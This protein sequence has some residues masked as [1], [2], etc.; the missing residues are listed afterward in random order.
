MLKFCLSSRRH[1]S[2]AIS[3]IGHSFHDQDISS[4]SLQDDR[5]N[6][7]TCNFRHLKTVVAGDHHDGT[8]TPLTPGICL[9]APGSKPS[10]NKDIQQ[11]ASTKS[12]NVRGSQ[13][14]LST[15]TLKAKKPSA[16][17]SLIVMA[18]F[19]QENLITTSATSPFHH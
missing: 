11:R 15:I 16:C 3:G 17:R 1:A 19:L 18:I 13:K 5:S 2:S 9:F 8:T 12:S 10:L 14:V 6:I 7:L 4:L